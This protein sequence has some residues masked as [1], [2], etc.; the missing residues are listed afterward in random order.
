LLLFPCHSRRNAPRIP[1]RNPNPLHR[2]GRR[3][4]WEPDY[5]S[6]QTA[7]VPR[8]A[9]NPSAVR[10]HPDRP[11]PHRGAFSSDLPEWKRVELEWER[12]IPAPRLAQRITAL[13]RVLQAPERWIARTARR[14]RVETGVIACLRERPPP[15]LRKPKLDRGAGPPL[16][17]ELAL[18]HARLSPDTS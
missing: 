12:V 16:E 6:Q 10:A 3:N 13:V 17:D 9:R 15:K 4:R 7:D 14:L 5:C 2:R 11:S 8:R 18:A 1:W